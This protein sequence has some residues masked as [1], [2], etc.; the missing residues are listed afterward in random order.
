MILLLN[1][2]VL[3]LLYHLTETT[4]PSYHTGSSNRLF[5]LFVEPRNIYFNVEG[6]RLMWMM[7]FA[8]T[9]SSILSLTPNG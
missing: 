7:I 5:G 9:L 4:F 6:S 2:L 3:H 8:V 1:H